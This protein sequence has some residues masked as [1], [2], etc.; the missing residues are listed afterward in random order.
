MNTTIRI[1]PLIAL[2]GLGAC[3]INTAPRQPDRVI[4]QEAPPARVVQPGTTTIVPPG[5]VVVPAR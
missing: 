1:A 3:S 4:V 2:L 5:S